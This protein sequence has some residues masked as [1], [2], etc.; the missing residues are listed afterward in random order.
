MKKYLILI[1][2][3]NAKVE[4]DGYVQR[5]NFHVTRL[6]EA[7]D[8]QAAQERAREE[9]AGELEGVIRNKS[10]DALVLYVDWM[11][12]VASFDE[13]SLPYDGGFVWYRE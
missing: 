2:G 7:E 11:Q 6:V 12:E 4:V 13:Y 8:A 9:I 5:C 1:S 3:V 10:R